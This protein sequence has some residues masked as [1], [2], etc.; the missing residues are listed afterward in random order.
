M[1][2]DMVSVIPNAVDAHVFTPDTSRR[3]PGKSELYFLPFIFWHKST[4]F[5]SGLSMMWT[6]QDQ[7][8]AMQLIEIK[9]NIS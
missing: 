9:S 8:T 1:K 2:P 3:T 4:S 6:I 7:N 5:L